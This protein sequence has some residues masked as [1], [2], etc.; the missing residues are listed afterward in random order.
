MATT[1]SSA[2]ASVSSFALPSPAEQFRRL[3]QLNAVGVVSDADLERAR[4][5]LLG[6]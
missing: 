2:P 4:R 6:T 1:E 5:V 3:S